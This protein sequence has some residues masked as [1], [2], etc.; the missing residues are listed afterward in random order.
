[1]G[2][3]D[4]DRRFAADPSADL[5]TDDIRL[6]DGTR[7]TDELAAEKGQRMI[8]EESRLRRSA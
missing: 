2:A 7:L 4:P 1:M 6:P 5:D 8:D 3:P